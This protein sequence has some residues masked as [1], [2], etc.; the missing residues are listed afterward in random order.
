MDRVRIAV[1]GAGL[2]GLRHLEEIQAN[3]ST[4][5]AAI[6]DP[7]P[8]AAVHAQRFGVALYRSLDEMLARDTP[9][10]VILSTPNPL[11]TEQGLACIQ[12]GLPTLIEKPIAP[13]I[14]EEL[15]LCEAAEAIVDAAKSGRIV[16]TL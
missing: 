6:V 2:I 9:D 7:A 14:D 4:A 12:A 8:Q 13:T 3:D 11:H 1:A 15:R 16:A 5:V 10:G